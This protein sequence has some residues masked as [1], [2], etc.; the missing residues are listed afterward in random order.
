VKVVASTAGR[1]S[2][3]IM[4]VASWTAKRHRTKRRH[5]LTRVAEQAADVRRRQ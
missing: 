3:A 2:K 1:V 5:R 4:A